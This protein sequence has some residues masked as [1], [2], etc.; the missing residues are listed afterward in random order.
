MITEYLKK[1]IAHSIF[2]GADLGDKSKEKAIEA[3]MNQTKYCDKND[4]L[5]SYIVASVNSATEFEDIE[6]DLQYAISQF[7]KAINSY[8]FSKLI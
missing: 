3:M 6:S 7:K 2:D 4:H 8:K 1:S 5:T